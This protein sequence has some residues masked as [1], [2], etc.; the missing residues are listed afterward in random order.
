MD[1]YKDWTLDP[2]KFADLPAVVNYL[3]SYVMQ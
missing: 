1:A 3:H 2:N